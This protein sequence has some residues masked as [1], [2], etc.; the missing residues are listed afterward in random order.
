MVTINGMSNIEM[1]RT[2]VNALLENPETVRMFEGSSEFGNPMLTVDIECIHW[3][4]TFHII[5][6]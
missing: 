5:A 1:A 2:F 6:D 3:T 4:R